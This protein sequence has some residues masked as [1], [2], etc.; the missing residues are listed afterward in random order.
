MSAPLLQAVAAYLAEGETSGLAA[1]A[2]AM[3]AGYTEG[4]SS[5]RA[6]TDLRAYLVARLPATYAACHKVMNEVRQLQ[7]QFNPGSVLD[8]G[9][10]PG[11]ASWAAAACWPDISSF[12]L[13]DSH[14]GL[15]A[16]ANRLCREAESPGLAAA[17]H[18][19]ADM[20]RDELPPPADLVLLSYA[21]AELPLNQVEAIAAK[22]WQAARSALVIIEPGTPAGF[23]RIRMAQ[24]KLLKLGASHISPCPH[25]N[26]CPLPGDDW[27]HFAVRLPR[28]RLHMHAKTA[29]VPFEDE[30]FSYLAVVREQVTEAAAKARILAPPK[31][32]KGEVALRLCETQGIVARQVARRHAASY[33]QAKKLTWGDALSQQEMEQLWPEN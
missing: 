5:A 20:T 10:G 3:T 15:A 27:C 2:R 31:V 33:K 32:S 25:Q 28:S 30:K 19:Q 4:Q 7:P 21:L 1:G 13:F 26:R 9:A 17:R 16:I 12:T 29:T 18:V 8:L 22:A 24:D 6:L 14:A 23:A 11:T